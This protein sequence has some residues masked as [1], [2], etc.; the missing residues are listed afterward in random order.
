LRDNGREAFRA[1]FLRTKSPENRLSMIELRQNGSIYFVELP[2]PS[3]TR[4]KYY[5]SAIIRIFNV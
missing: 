4:K 1:F 2:Q 3:L 5:K